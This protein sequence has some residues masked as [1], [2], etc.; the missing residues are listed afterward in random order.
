ML[1]V[2]GV[3]ICA[4]LAVVALADVIR[5]PVLAEDAASLSA[6]DLLRVIDARQTL[7]P[8]PIVF[9]VPLS[10]AV[11]GS[12]RWWIFLGAV[13]VA[14]GLALVAT[15]S[16]RRA[17]RPPAGGRWWLSDQH[18]HAVA[19]PAV[20]AVALADSPRRSATVPSPPAPGC[21]PCADSPPT[22]GWPSTPS[23]PGHTGS[24]RTAWCRRA[25][26]PVRSSP[27]PASARARTRPARRRRVRR[28]RDRARARPR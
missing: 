26:G 23:W 27:R 4:G 10:T 21:R 7:Y 19:D 12:G 6:D 15:W 22:S 11:G 16:R 20:R 8:F 24:W 9:A 17:G 13:A 5:R 14:W 1:L 3:T 25:A 28:H 2:L 18:R